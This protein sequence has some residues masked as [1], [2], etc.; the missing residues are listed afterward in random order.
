MHTPPGT[1]LCLEQ[2]YTSRGIRGGTMIVE[3]VLDLT[4]HEARL[5]DPDGYRPSTCRRCRGTRL[6]AHCFRGRRLRSLCG[7]P[8]TDVRIRLYVCPDKSCR[9][10]YTVL[11]GLVPRHLSYDWATAG[12]AVEARKGVPRT[13]LLRWLRRLATSVVCLL[14]RFHAHA[15]KATSALLAA[16]RPSDRKGFVETLSRRLGTHHLFGRVAA[17]IHRLEPG[18]RLM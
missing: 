2:P 6:H 8:A 4:S 15:D 12:R 3:E 14:Q 18:I 16:E 11:P 10:V 13:T 17:W 9:A 1:P 7:E 5:L